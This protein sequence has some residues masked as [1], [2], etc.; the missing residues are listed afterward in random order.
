[1][2]RLRLFLPLCGL[3]LL[4]LML[5]LGFSLNDPHILPSALLE[6]PFPEFELPSL[7]DADKIL[8]REDLKGKI[9]L[10]NV[11]ATWCPTCKAEHAE[12][13]RLKRQFGLEIVGIVYKDAPDNARGWLA[14][15]GDPYTFNIVDREGRLGIDLGVYGAPESFLV[16]AE[17]KILYK[18]VGE[19]NARIWRDEI[20]PRLEQLEY[21][22]SDLQP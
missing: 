7:Q 17:G 6:K 19:V 4:V 14:A 11:W 9:L 12:L 1:M 22:G 2:G 3:L 13:M 20:S 8:T 5:W 21:S 18:R 16:N 15:Y 10:V